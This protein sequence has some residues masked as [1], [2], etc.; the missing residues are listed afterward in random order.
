V[1]GIVAEHFGQEGSVDKSFNEI[2]TILTLMD[3]SVPAYMGQNGPVDDCKEISEAVRFII[4]EA[5]KTEDL[6]SEEKSHSIFSARV[7]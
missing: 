7:P 4:E 5:K 1:E 6:T 3:S 2:K